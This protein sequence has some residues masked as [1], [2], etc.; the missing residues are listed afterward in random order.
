[1]PVSLLLP[2]D[3]NSKNKNRA[4]MKI[5]PNSKPRRVQNI[6]S[7]KT[8]PDFKPR[9]AATVKRNKTAPNFKTSQNFAQ[10]QNF[11]RFSDFHGRGGGRRIT[12]LKFVRGL[13]KIILFLARFTSMS[14]SSHL[15]GYYRFHFVLENISM[16]SNGV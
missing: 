10:F 2:T 3:S 11:A 6:T 16:V 12:T 15:N 14:H 7:V 4:G 5:I 8:T 1:M 13:S 9:G